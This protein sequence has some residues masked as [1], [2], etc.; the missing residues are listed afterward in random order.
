MTYTY[1]SDGFFGY[2]EKG[3]FSYFSFAHFI[4]LI[5]LGVVIFLE[6][7]YRNKLKNSKWD[8]R[9]RFI[10]AF[11]LIIAEMSYY[12]RLMYIGGSYVTKLPIT[13]CGWMTILCS[14]MLMS[15]NK[16]LFEICYFMVF[17][18]GLMP[19]ITPAVIVTTGPAY[20]RYYQFWIQHTGTIIA[21]CY[22]MFSYGFRPTWK[23]ALKSLG[24]FVVITA[25]SLWANATIEGANCLF[26]SNNAAGKSALDLLPSNMWAKT[27]CAGAIVLVLYFLA[28]LPWLIIDIV[29]KKKEKAVGEV[30]IDNPIK[31]ESG[32][33]VEGKK[34]Q[35]ISDKAKQEKYKTK[36]KAITKKA[37]RKEIS[38]K[39]KK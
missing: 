18:V 35:K 2:G 28:Y 12:W 20:Y 30:T 37:T 11:I 8:G 19:L 9:L 10:L 14:F 39:D 26:L 16:T 17:T 5:L 1:R 15:K 3:D 22:M 33:I 34:E 7:R 21:L 4:P 23:S 25:L 6:W 13:V 29:K 32:L 38:T 24:V 27:A 36:E 31:A